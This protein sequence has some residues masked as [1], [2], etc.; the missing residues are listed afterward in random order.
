MSRVSSLF[1][2]S[3]DLFR[4]VACDRRRRGVGL[5]MSTIE[6]ADK[7]YTGKK[8]GHL[9]QWITHT[10]KWMAEGEATGANSRLYVFPCEM[11]LFL[12]RFYSS[13]WCPEVIQ[14]ENSL[15]RDFSGG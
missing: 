5:H 15:T 3:R 14:H 8:F 12:L 9:G 1:L 11:P 4:L 10:V 6:T 7:R 13:L 2:E